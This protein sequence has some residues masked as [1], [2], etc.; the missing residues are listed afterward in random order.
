MIGIIGGDRQW[1]S[2]ARQV[3]N[4]DLPLPV[5]ACREGHRPPVWRERGCLFQSTRS[6]S[7]RCCGTPGAGSGATMPA[8][9]APRA[10]SRTT[11]R[12]SA[13]MEPFA[14]CSRPRASAPSSSS[15]RASPI[16]LTRR[17]GFFSKH[18]RSALRTP[19]GVGAGSAVHSVPVRGSGPACRSRC[20]PRM[21]AVP[22]ASRT[23]RS[24][25]P[26]Y[27]YAC[28]RPPAGLLGTHVGRCAQKH[29]NPGHHRRRG[30]GRRCHSLR[31]SGG[32]R[33]ECLRQS[34]VQHLDNAI[35]P[36]LHV[37]RFQIAMNDA[38]SWAASS[39]SAICLA[40]GSASS[41]GIG[42]CA[43]R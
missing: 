31:A 27:P 14:A 1:L 20:R 17:R 36:H 13:H 7:R 24:R 15:I 11:A 29:A 6:L 35:G 30:D 38:C 2:A 32:Y 19:S 40:I 12:P 5:H 25:T 18:R 39:A 22:S 16:S 21:P 37:V 23:A 3:L 10:S 42:P 34:E 8:M 9:A 33:F 41:S 4:E 26:R 43:M 28:R